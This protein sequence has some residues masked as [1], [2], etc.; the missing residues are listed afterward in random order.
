MKKKNTF[1][2][3]HKR[4]IKPLF[5]FLLFFILN[6]TSSIYAQ[7]TG[8]PNDFDCD[9]IIDALDVDDDND[10]IFDH[11]ESPGCFE[12]DK[13]TYETGDRRDRLE[14]NTTLPYASGTVEQLVDGVT[15]AGGISIPVSTNI[16]NQ[17]IFRL[18]TKL[19]AGIQ[20][21]SI[22]MTSSTNMFTA[23]A[24]MVLQGSK[25]GQNWI[26]LAANFK[27][28]TRPTFTFKIDTDKEDL[29][30]H[31]RLWGIS[32]ATYPVAQN[33]REITG[34]VEN[35]M[36][37]LYP[38]A[39]CEGE[40]IDKDGIPNHHDLNS[41]GDN[42]K[43]V[44]EAGFA[45]DDR[46]GIL[47]NSPVKVNEY[48][49]VTS[50]IGY[51]TPNNM[52][53]LDPTK[54]FCT[55]EGIPID[56]NS[57]CSDLDDLNSDNN[58]AQS[59]FHTTI[60]STK[61]G[62]SIF[63]QA[64]S[65]SGSG[66]IYTP[67]PMTPENGFTYEGQIRL[68]SLAGRTG[69]FNDTRFFIL[70]TEGL[71]TWGPYLNVS[72]PN[73]WVTKPGFSE[74]QLPSGITPANIKN[75]SA[76]LTNLVLL[77]KSG[78]I[79]IASGNRASPNP[80]IYGDR[81]TVLDDKWHKAVIGNVVSIKINSWGQA[82]AVTMTGEVYTW[83]HKI[84]LGDGSAPQTIAIPTK[85]TLPTSVKK[86]KMTAFTYA[87][88]ATYYILGQDKRVYSLGSSAY[89]NLGVGSLVSSSLWQ[90]VKSPSGTGTG[91][92]TDYL[93]NIKFITA[94][95][96]DETAGAAGA[97]DEDG[98]PYFWGENGHSRLGSPS[99]YL[100]LPRIPDGVTPGFHNIISVEMGGH[101][102]PIIDKRLGKFGYIGHLTAGSMGIPGEGI[103]TKY[104]FEKTPVVDFCNIV[105][106]GP[107][108]MRVTVNPMNINSTIKK[109]EE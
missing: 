109:V 5:I 33:L 49:A 31:Y 3:Y 39:K 105:I 74:I 90:T 65:P 95:L 54:N 107:K 59:I 56:E 86:V 29:Y 9:G 43:D 47:G 30:K 70:S 46:D 11:I 42:C 64:A 20:Y 45:D 81:S 108:K 57:Y 8:C 68:A 52:Y 24:E 80:A 13:K 1:M 63:G 23:T 85:M 28:S 72:I 53:W 96:H 104:D 75:M 91:T 88:G 100:L 101:V 82:L 66:H 44:L 34:V 17:E 78:D 25:D 92:G 4:K 40:D 79:Y 60:V 19:T 27:P 106:G 51:I 76:S 58:L 61:N 10:G 83:G 77:T 67:T 97:I 99:I 6:F 12:L 103:I 14:F 89:G 18:T 7:Q 38:K 35:Y 48:G 94:T 73:G 37:S 15:N 71:Y 21:S 98:V 22:I 26:P 93:E 32:G 87:E 84:Y 62:Y 102:T 41:D 36:P 55:G 16:T 50:A 69:G 2:K